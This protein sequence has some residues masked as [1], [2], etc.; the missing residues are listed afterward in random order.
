MVDLFGALPSRY[1]D[2]GDVTL[3][4]QAIQQELDRLEKAVRTLGARGL[5]A[6]A[7]REGLA[8]WETQLGLPHRPDLT[9]ECRRAILHA[10][11]DRCYDG[12]AAALAEYVQRL[13]GVP[14]QVRQEH[15]DYALTVALEDTGRVDRYS[16]Q[17]WVDRCLPV[18]IA[19]RV[20][21]GDA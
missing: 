8:L 17:H 18:H 11:L 2:C 10:A 7:D 12:T 5:V 13:T 19:G 1:G 4:L 14:A 16:V 20:E 15:P 6:E 21:S 3:L 9:E